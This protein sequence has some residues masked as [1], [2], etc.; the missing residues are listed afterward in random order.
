MMLQII[1]II[2]FRLTTKGVG[3]AIT[4]G[5]EIDLAANLARGGT[6]KRHRVGVDP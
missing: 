1:L 4:S 5:H 6:E 3:R 2:E